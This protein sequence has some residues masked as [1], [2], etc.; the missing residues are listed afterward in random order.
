MDGFGATRGSDATN[1]TDGGDGGAAG[2]GSCGANGGP[3][4]DI[5]IIVDESST[6]LL[7]AVSWDLRGG[8][9]GRAGKHGTPGSGGTGGTGGQG[10]RWE[11]IVGYKYFCTDS[12]IKHDAHAERSSTSTTMIRMGS[13]LHASSSALTAPIGAL[14]VSGNNLQRAIVQARRAYHAVERPRADPGACKCGGGTG[15][16]TGCNMKPI[17]KNFKRAPGLDGKDGETGASVTTPLLK[18]SKGAEGAITIAVQNQG[19][20]TQRYTSV[21]SLEVVDFDIEDDNADGIFEPGEYLHI[22]RVCVKNLGG[23]P[24]PTCQIPVTLADHSENLEEVSSTDGGVAYLPTSIPPAGEALMEGSIK[25]RIKPNTMPL[26][27]GTR[28]REK[29]WLKIRADMPWLQRR[30]P[31]FELLKEVNIAYPCGFGDFDNLST[32]SQGAMS[33]IRYQVCFASHDFQYMPSTAKR[34]NI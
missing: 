2:Q 4:G 10:W 29:A 18:G 17:V 19:G 20:P 7:M 9:G 6:H 23:M 30:L 22:Q 21:W 32:V 1:G 28:F 16:C 8:I 13:R 3:G 12:C 26:P 14:L 11:E 24:S 15:N 31:S 5:H 27:L 34:Q 25:V 33:M